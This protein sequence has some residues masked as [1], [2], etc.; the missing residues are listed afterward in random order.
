M[1]INMM[2]TIF[3][4][5]M[6][7]CMMACSSLLYGQLGT[8]DT[9]TCISMAKI[10]NKKQFCD[11]S[12]PA[13]FQLLPDTSSSNIWQ[14][15]HT[16]KFGVTNARDSACSIITDTLNPYPMNNLSMFTV[17]LPENTS[18]GWNYN[19]YHYC[20]TKIIKG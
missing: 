4:Y 20:P 19:Y 10:F 6:T 1:K 9:N 13:G 14:V 7:L 15:G 8:L 5:F 11:T 2:K 18:I 12:S 17:I 16:I 3:S